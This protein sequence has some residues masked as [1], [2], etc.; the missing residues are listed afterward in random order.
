MTAPE[1]KSAQRG[2]SSELLDIPGP[3]PSSREA[4]KRLTRERL[5]TAGE[6]EFRIRGYNE[7][8][9]ENIATSAGT[10]RAT[11]Y[12][13]FKSKAE[14]VL[15][16]MQRSSPD[17]LRAYSDLDAITKPTL[18]NVKAWLRSTMA[19]WDTRRSDFTIMEQALANDDA[20]TDMWIS[21]LAN[22]YQVMPRTFGRF[23][24]AKDHEKARLH[25]LTLQ[26]ALERMMYFA[27]IRRRP[28]KMDLLLD[29][30]ADQW[31][32]FLESTF[33]ESEKG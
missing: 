16:L 18:R 3:K 33:P 23:T 4:Q 8:T 5:I 29:T 6:A 27:V 12:V 22:S 28:V 31:L 7:T 26:S 13:Y 15:E 20:V 30:L 14:V 19:L 32:A 21:T 11:F 10:S 2:R 24:N 1:K 17:V 9:A 25:L